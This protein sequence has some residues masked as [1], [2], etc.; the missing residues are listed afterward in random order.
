MTQII[1]KV[2]LST[3]EGN[4]NTVSLPK[5]SKV[6]ACAFQGENLVMWFL[7][8]YNN[9][10]IGEKRSF[11]IVRTGEHFDEPALEYIGTA[12]DLSSIFVLHVFEKVITERTNE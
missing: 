9:I 5:G 2:T 11:Y 1:H 6:I 12:S 7:F 3:R 10:S 8:E 4:L